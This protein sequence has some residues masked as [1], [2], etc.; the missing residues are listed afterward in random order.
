[1]NADCSNATL[2]DHIER[3]QQA[4]RVM[5]GLSD[6]QRANFDLTCWDSCIASFCA[7]DPWFRERGFS[8]AHS[9][10]SEQL[11]TFFGREDPFY[12]AYYPSFHQQQPVTVEEAI[13]ALNQSIDSL[14][15]AT[16]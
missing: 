6:V 14:K 16:A 13:A 10:M 12:P 5:G 11:T 4:V 8:T 15:S 3:L 1:M 9:E 2:A 7:L